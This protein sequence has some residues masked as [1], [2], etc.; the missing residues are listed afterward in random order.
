MIE[1]GV[2]AAISSA[3]MGG[4]FF[5]FSSFVMTALNNVS[6]GEGIRI[7][8]RIN[9]DVFSWSFTILFLSIPLSAIVL[10][11][12]AAFHWSDAGSV[13]YVAG[14]LVYLSGAVLVTGKGNIPLNNVLA[15]LDPNTDIAHSTWKDYLRTWTRW[16][17][18]RTVACILTSVLFTGA[19][20]AG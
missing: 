13:Y 14:C 12:D 11:I 4:I 9:I 8:Q 15:R 3:L 19:S 6:P 5:A 1:L 20:L 18:A 10:A 16:N 17:H 2:F 7:M